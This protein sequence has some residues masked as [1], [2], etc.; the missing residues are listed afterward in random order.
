MD[1]S[2]HLQHLPMA[3]TVIGAFTTGLLGA[4][5]HCTLMC[6]GF[7]LTFGVR[8]GRRD[9]LR[10]GLFQT[11]R[12]LTY[13]VMALAL[14]A[15]GESTRWLAPDAGRKFWSVGLGVV[16]LVMAIA[17]GWPEGARISRV[18]GVFAQ[19]LGAVMRGARAAGTPGWLL[20]GMAWGL[21]PCAFSW[22]AIVG[23]A[24]AGPKLAPLIAAAFGLGTALPL[25]AL[26]ELDRGLLARGGAIM[27]RALA[28]LLAV[29]A[30][31]T[32]ARGLR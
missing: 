9:R 6:G 25:Q 17:V 10:L 1:H 3:W 21:L 24:A 22:A 32:I 26:G 11:G 8:D 18:L 14:A 29:W 2:Q 5:A 19:R 15:L 7:V 27:R 13:A 12:M 30:V 23:A 31:W 4:F 20:A 16:M 28:I